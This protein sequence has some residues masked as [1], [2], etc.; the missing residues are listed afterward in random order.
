MASH[1]RC[2]QGKLLVSNTLHLQHY[3]VF[4]VCIQHMANGLWNTFIEAKDHE[5][6]VQSSCSSSPIFINAIR[7]PFLVNANGVILKTE[8]NV[9]VQVL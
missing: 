1:T 6:H 7:T 5:T 2:T 8:D 3:K 9:A 4:Q